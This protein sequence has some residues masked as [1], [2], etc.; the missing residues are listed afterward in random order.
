M[1]ILYNVYRG[2]YV[3]LVMFTWAHE[4][5]YSH[6]ENV[7]NCMLPD[8]YN[9][10][11]INFTLLEESVLPEE[12]EFTAELRVNVKTTEDT[13]KWISDFERSS[14]TNYNKETSDR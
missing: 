1:Q 5:D 11:I 4:P 12:T 3:K 7:L 14:R 2:C 8:S 13:F 10:H 9:Y 6:G